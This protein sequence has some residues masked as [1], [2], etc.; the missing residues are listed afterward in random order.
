MEQGY[1]VFVCG[2]YKIFFDINKHMTSFEPEMYENVRINKERIH[3]VCA[4]V[5]IC[6]SM[7]TCPF[8]IAPCNFFNLPLFVQDRI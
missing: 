2:V 3:V 7:V 8:N 1:R 4:Y 5:S 6:L